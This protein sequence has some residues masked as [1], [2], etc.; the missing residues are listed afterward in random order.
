MALERPPLGTLSPEQRA[1]LIEGLA[2]IE[3]LCDSPQLQARAR[4][5]LC[6]AREHMQFVRENLARSA[7][8]HNKMEAPSSPVSLRAAHNRLSALSLPFEIGN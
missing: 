1:A 7:P 6:I 8:K 2:Q 3:K 4:T 5:T